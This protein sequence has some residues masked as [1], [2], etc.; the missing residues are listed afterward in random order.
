MAIHAME[1]VTDGYT[2]GHTPFYLC[3][4]GFLDTYSW[5]PRVPGDGTWMERGWLTTAWAESVP[6][7]STWTPRDNPTTPSSS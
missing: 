4:D 5:R 1:M 6:G 3:T 2:P 7:A